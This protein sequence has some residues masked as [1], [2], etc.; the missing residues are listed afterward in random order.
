MCTA[1]EDS[2]TIKDDLLAKIVAMCSKRIC[3]RLK[4]AKKKRSSRSDAEKKR[5]SFKTALEKA[6]EHVST[7][8]EG[9]ESLDCSDVSNASGISE[10]SESLESPPSAFIKAAKNVIRKL[11]AWAKH[12]VDARLVDVVDAV[13]ELDSIK[14]HRDLIRGVPNNILDPNLRHSLINIITKIARYKE[15]GRTLYSRAK[16]IPQLRNMKVV[17]VALP[18]ACWH[19]SPPL[20]T[21]LDLQS[22]ILRAGAPKKYNI[23]LICRF[24]KEDRGEAE[25]DFE[26]QTRST[27]K[28]GK[29]HAE[30][31]IL[32]YCEHTRPAFPPRVV[33]SSKDACYLCN[34]FIAAHQKWHTPRTHGKLY[35]GWRLPKLA[36]M[37]SVEDQ[38]NQLLETQV[39]QSLRLLMHRRERTQY[40]DPAESTIMTLV[41]SCSTL[42]ESARAMS[43]A[44][45]ERQPYNGRE[46]CSTKGSEDPSPVAAE[47]AAGKADEEKVLPEPNAADEA[48]AEIV[49][50]M[51]PAMSKGKALV[52]ETMTETMPASSPSLR[53]VGTADIVTESTDSILDSPNVRFIPVEAGILD[54]AQPSRWIDLK[55]LSIQLC[56]PA[57][58]KAMAF[59]H[60]RICEFDNLSPQLLSLDI[61]DLETLSG[62]VVREL[63]RGGSLYLCHAGQVLQLRLRFIDEPTV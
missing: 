46:T 5:D 8:A 39:K 9:I 30:I 16:H 22:T 24:L 36:A 53:P 13:H 6:I 1:A 35:P 60:K 28:D 57:A 45:A 42:R 10:S 47:S 3:C 59:E 41:P 4:L 15:S 61:V 21:D 48:V 50:P 11:N 26:E 56:G 38:F 51:V 63:D 40:V 44:E 27:L 23:D 55:N 17:I 20:Q 7:L 25:E 29:F 43:S 19:R 58:G 34:A 12:Q 14:G 52:A 49:P 2:R 33:C 32:Y 37:T 62:E 54:A 18:A 31:Q